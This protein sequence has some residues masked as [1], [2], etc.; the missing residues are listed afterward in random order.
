MAMRSPSTD[1]ACPLNSSR[2]S[3]VRSSE[4]LRGFVSRPIAGKRSPPLMSCLRGVDR[5]YCPPI[6]HPRKGPRVN[7]NSS[8]PTIGLGFRREQTLEASM[9]HD[10][11]ALGSMAGTRLDA[12]V[13][14]RPAT[15][16]LCS[17]LALS[18][19]VL[20]AGESIFPAVP[21]APVLVLAICA[22]L[23]DYSSALTR[24]PPGGEA[25]ARQLA[26]RL[27]VA[28]LLAWSAGLVAGLTVL[29][30]LALWALFVLLDATARNV[31]APLHQRL[32]RRERWILVG[33]EQTAERLR[34]FRAA[35][36]LRRAGRDGGARPRRSPRPSRCRRP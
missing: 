14:I 12:T 4:A 35:A 6:S 15:D 26:T 23:G 19:V 31:S 25:R 7:S 18:V 33:D 29:A 36:G 16:L 3:R 17:V 10:R 27:L 13:W 20:V 32:R 11:P 9:V 28:A 24:V 8:E 5:R 1:T 34:G 2:N 21:V 30:Q 22:I